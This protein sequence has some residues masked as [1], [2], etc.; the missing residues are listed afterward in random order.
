M[1]PAR[2]YAKTHIVLIPSHILLAG[3]RVSE[4]TR[5]FRPRDDS[6]NRQD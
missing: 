3:T 6:D 2:R 1:I 4:H 5:Y